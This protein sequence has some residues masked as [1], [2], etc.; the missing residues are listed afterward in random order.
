MEDDST[1][2]TL[3]A[4]VGLP[5]FAIG[6]LV[7]TTPALQGQVVRGRLVDEAGDV[8][9]AGAM[10]TLLD[11][12]GEIIDRIL[13]RSGT[14]TFVLMASGA[15]DYRVRAER[16]GF[17]TTF[18]AFFQLAQNDTVT[19]QIS[20]PIEPVSLAE[21]R[22]EVAPRC[23]V[24]PDEGMAVA[25]VWNEARKAL[26]V[27]AWTQSRGLYRYEM[28]GIRRLFDEDRKR[29]VHEE[30]IPAQSR[31]PVPYVARAADSLMQ[32][33]FAHISAEH[34]TF[35]APDAGV[36]LSDDFLDTHCMKV[37][38]VGSERVG[39]DFEPVQ[40][41]TL[42]EI[43]G[44]MWLDATT[45]EL[46]R[47]DFSYVNLPVPRWLMDAEPGGQVHFRPLP[48]GTWIVTS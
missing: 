3:H 22:A 41:R 45:A 21:I 8:A 48:D 36:L 9:I 32:E 42:P 46:R 27:A 38:S 18:S 7:A 34:S 31:V 19:I 15:G 30:R 37:R 1:M 35:W 4:R 12:D 13:S 25:R 6:V 43:R 23:D 20:A 39:L 33:G 47:V 24:R 10:M 29:I 2:R 40:G 17:A 5:V 26:A 44:T 16:I 11:R 28:L 14:G